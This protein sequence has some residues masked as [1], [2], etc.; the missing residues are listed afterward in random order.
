MHPDPVVRITGVTYFYGDT[1]V[2]NGIDL[3]VEQRDFLVIHGPNGGGK[4]TL[5]KLIMGV[6]RPERGTIEVFGG[7]PVSASRRIGYVPQDLTMPRGFPATVADVVLMGRVG[8]GRRSLRTSPEDRMHAE[9]AMETVGIA[10]L[11]NE[12]I[13]ALSGGQRQRAFIAR[14]LASDP[15][16]FILDEP[17]ANIDPAGQERIHRILETLNSRMTIIVVSHDYALTFGVATRIAHLNHTIHVHDA[18]A[19]SPEFAELLMIMSR[20]DMCPVELANRGLTTRRTDIPSG[21]DHV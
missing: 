15:E 21:A 11:R 3:T 14:A 10:D 9:T 1:V 16:L 2:F 19:A 6:L 5:L 13:E 17:T 7:P 8:T 4:T 20:D 18:N 12:R